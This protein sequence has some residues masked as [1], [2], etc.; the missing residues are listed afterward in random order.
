MFDRTGREPIVRVTLFVP[1]TAALEAGWQAALSAGAPPAEARWLANDGTFGDAFRLGTVG[2]ELRAQIDVAAGAVILHWHE[3]LGGGR[4]PIARAIG[5]LREVGALA[6]RLEQSKLGWPI[7]TW[8]EHFDRGGDAYRGAVVALGG[9]DHVQTCG[10][11]AFS[12]PDVRL[13]RAGATAA[14][15]GAFVAALCRYQIDEAPM[16]RSGQTFRPDEHTA[17]RVIERWPDDGY[18]A[19]HACHNPYGVWRLGPPGGTARA[20]GKLELM[21]MPSLAAILM[22]LE[23]RHGAPLTRAQVEAARDAAACVA[24]VPHD[25][26]ALER[27]RGY[28]DLEPERA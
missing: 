26:L 17:R 6:V 16:L 7:D 2:P 4:A 20:I 23:A 15:V 18:P 14:Q 21:F 9:E 13:P 24:M 11:H 1:G 12:L 3:D 19:D 27:S 28:A 5:R 25:A 22:D 10:M 8:L